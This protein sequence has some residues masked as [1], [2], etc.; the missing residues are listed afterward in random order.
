MATSKPTL[1]RY[2]QLQ[3]GAAVI[4]AGAR[5]RKLVECVVPSI[6]T[7][8]IDI[9]GLF[10]INAYRTLARWILKSQL[11]LIDP[12]FDEAFYLSQIDDNRHRR[13][14]A[15]DPQLHYLLSGW[16]QGL[17]PH[18]DFDP[19]AYKERAGVPWSANP[20]LH[21]AKQ[22]RGQPPNVAMGSLQR[23]TVPASRYS[24]TAERNSDQSRSVSAT[25]RIAIYTAVIGSYDDLKQPLV[26]LPNCDLFVFSEEPVNAPGW[27]VVPR[28]LT[29]GDTSREARFIKLHPHLFFQNYD[30]SIWLDA[31]ITI[32][33]DI[34]PLLN[35]LQDGAYCASFIHPFRDC[36]YEEARECVALGK[37][38]SVTMLDQIERY[39]QEEYP[40]HAG[41][42]ETNV[43]VRRHNDPR[44]IEL[45]TAWWRELQHGSRRDQ[46]SLP[47][48]A[49]RLGAH[50]APLDNAGVDARRH[51]L[52]ALSPHKYPPQR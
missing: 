47:V 17:R 29:Q 40:P 45:M 35:V 25:Q 41:L 3:I 9:F 21:F 44:C 6:A 50:I 34:R 27:T 20:L 28:K 16:F 39:R 8:L 1:A 30:I 2:L 5:S 7:F 48:V 37:D 10:R 24:P 14:A 26:A 22:H 49:R 32:K 11:G 4:L 18:P 12:Y 52:F 38:S 51:P 42:W 31:N 19:P 33:D 43:L 13:G 15:T 23:V 46:L 36:V